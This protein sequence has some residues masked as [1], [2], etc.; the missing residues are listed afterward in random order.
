MARRAGGRRGRG[1]LGR[2][3]VVARPD[4]PGAS[5]SGPRAPGVRGADP[6]PPPDPGRRAPRRPGGGGVPG[7]AGVPV[8]RDGG[9]LGPLRRGRRPALAPGPVRLDEHRR[10]VGRGPRGDVWRRVL[11]GDGRRRRRAVRPPARRVRQAAGPGHHRRHDAGAGRGRRVG[12]QCRRPRVVRRRPWTHTCVPVRDRTRRRHRRDGALG[13]AEAGR[14]W[15]GTQDR[16]L[17]S[18]DRAA[19][20]LRPVDADLPSPYVTALLGDRAGRLWVGTTNGLVVYEGGAFRRVTALADADVESLLED[21]A[22]DLWVGTADGLDHLDPETGALARYRHDPD[23]PSSLLP[24]RVRS[25]ALDRSGTIWAGAGTG[26][27]A[28]RWSAPPIG[29][30]TAGPDGL[31]APGVIAVLEGERRGGLG[32]DRGRA[33]PPGRRR[34]AHAPRPHGP[35]AGRARAGVRREPVRGRRRDALGRDPR[36]SPR[37]QARSTNSTPPRAASS[38]GSRRARAMGTSRPPTRGA[39]R[40]TAGVGSGCSPTARGA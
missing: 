17:A 12:R 19:G 27:S 29:L 37:P 15:V 3:P 5:A 18:L 21:P 6:V 7:L 23:D 14:V 40:P 11:A 1:G 35:G 10:R 31:S 8:G 4:R 28:F 9:R 13:G 32:R 25:L 26:V 30:V 39:S 38:V 16:G 24:G 34:P 33:R 20:R 22:G 36:Q 2:G